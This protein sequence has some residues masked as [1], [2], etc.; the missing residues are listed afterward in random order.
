MSDKMEYPVTL[1]KQLSE[2]HSEG[3]PYYLTQVFWFVSLDIPVDIHLDEM[4]IVS[5]SKS[6]MM[7]TFL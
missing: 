1:Y 4:Y 7:L 3:I 5:A 2:D 6:S